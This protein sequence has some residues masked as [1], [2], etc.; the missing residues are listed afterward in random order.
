[1]VLVRRSRA[2]RDLTF[3]LCAHDRV[4]LTWSRLLCSDRT[5][6]IHA[7]DARWTSTRRNGRKLKSN[8]DACPFWRRIWEFRARVFRVVAFVATQSLSGVYKRKITL[9]QYLTLRV[10]HNVDMFYFPLFL[11][12]ELDKTPRVLRGRNPHANFKYIQPEISK[13]FTEWRA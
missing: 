3:L 10:F 13:W 11:Y 8:A 6:L 9:S 2:H 7:C 1:M 5:T 12:L 4:E